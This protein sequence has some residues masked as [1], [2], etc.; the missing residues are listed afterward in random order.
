MSEGG[1]RREDLPAVGLDLAVVVAFAAIGRATHGEGTVPT[2]VL[3]A[4]LPFAVAALTAHLTL[5]W[6]R[7]SPRPVLAGLFVWA[8]TFLGGLVGRLLLGETAEGAFALVAGAVLAAGM[9][10]WRLVNDLRGRP[11]TRSRRPAP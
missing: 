3:R 9:L 6:R 2:E 10:V 4:A 7:Q 11:R 1:Q 8:V 5:N